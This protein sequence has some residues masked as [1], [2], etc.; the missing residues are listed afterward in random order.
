MAESIP[1]TVDAVDW[2]VW[3]PVDRATLLFVIRDGQILLI[4]KKRG[5]GAGK[6]NGPGGRVE[7]GESPEQ[8]ALREVEEELGVIPT[9][10]SFGGELAFQF[11]DAYS[12][13]VHVYR[14]TGCLGTARETEEAIPLWTPLAEIPYEEMWADDRLWLPLLLRR[15]PFHGHFIFDGDKMLDYVLEQGKGSV[16]PGSEL[17]GKEPG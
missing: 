4:R 1:R 13:H 16:L 5:L 11:V 12:I 14:A 7:A 17:L 9:G 15:E 2:A 3:T 8:C 6:V 10:L